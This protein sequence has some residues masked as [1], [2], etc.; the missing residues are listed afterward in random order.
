MLF[1]TKS[2]MIAVVAI[3]TV[4]VDAL[5]SATTTASDALRYKSI[6]EVTDQ[7]EQS[8]AALVQLRDNDEQADYED[9]AFL[10]NPFSRTLK[11]GDKVKVKENGLNLGV[12]IVRDWSWN[13]GKRLYWVNFGSTDDYCTR[14]QLERVGGCFSFVANVCKSL[15]RKLMSKKASTDGDQRVQTHYGMTPK[16]FYGR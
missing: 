13:N 12:G 4:G 10:Q 16:I 11:P 5:K 15:K 1:S 2:S 8:V 6:S 9:T 7:E 14:N 3:A